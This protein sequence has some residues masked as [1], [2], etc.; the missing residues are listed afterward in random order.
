MPA[1]GRGCHPK[2]AT[3]NS[4]IVAVAL[5][6]YPPPMSALEEFGY[7]EQLSRALTTRDLVVYGMIFMVPIAP[8]SPFGFVWNEA[9]G[10]VP[11]AYLI[12]LIGIAVY[13]RCL[14]AYGPGFPARGFGIHLCPP[15]F[16]RNGGFLL[17]VADTA[18]LHLGPGAAL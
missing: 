9:K 11:L 17:R 8:Y 10:M 14:C 6:H 4:C 3:P 18:R 2:S 1:F 12:C 13:G 7:T 15:G 5:T 16:A